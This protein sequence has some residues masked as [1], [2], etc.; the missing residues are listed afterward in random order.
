M[1]TLLLEI[2]IIKYYYEKY[3]I[4]YYFLLKIVMLL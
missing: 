2:A 4:N 3:Y 1:N